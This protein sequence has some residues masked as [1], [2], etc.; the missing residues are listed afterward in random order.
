MKD[1]TDNL[2]SGLAAL[3]EEVRPVDLRDRTLWTSRRLAVRRTAIAAVAGGLSAGLITTGVAFALPSQGEAPP[4]LST[5]VPSE[6]TTTEPPIEGSTAPPVEESS[7]PTEQVPRTEIPAEAML[8]AEDLGPG[9][10][11]SDDT[12]QDHGGLSMLMAYCGLTSGEETLSSRL[13]SFSAG[14]DDTFGQQETRRYEGDGARAAFMDMNGWL[15]DCPRVEVG[16]N[17]EYVSELTVIESG[18]AGEGSL[19]LE[20]V[21]STPDG[22]TTRYQAV[23]QQGDLYTEV[24]LPGV[25]AD[26]ALTVATTVAG[27]LCE[28]TPS[29]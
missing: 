18:F 5:V 2:R 9:Y 14:D 24:R 1:L 26:W 3:A 11:T 8:R 19:L 25:S 6:L 7:E 16:G 4:P 20:E 22:T 10:E 28:A 15:A 12:S 23:V 17:P 27:R 13:R 21:Y 29:C